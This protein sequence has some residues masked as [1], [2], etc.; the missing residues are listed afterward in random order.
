MMTEYVQHVAN[1]LVFQLGYK[2]PVW[3]KATSPFPFMDRIALKNKSNFMEKHVSEYKRA[4][5]AQHKGPAVDPWAVF[6]E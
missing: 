2:E 1:R 4:T 6:K 3:P 5:T